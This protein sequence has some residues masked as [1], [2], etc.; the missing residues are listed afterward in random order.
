MQPDINQT[1]AIASF[2]KQEC[3]GYDNRTTNAMLSL[4]FDMPDR[5]KAGRQGI[6]NSRRLTKL[7]NH[8]RELGH[9]IIADSSGI[10][11]AEFQEDVRGMLSDY[12]GRARI[13]NRQADLIEDAAEKLPRRG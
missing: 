5:G 13:F 4:W 8:A 10:Y 2:L 11:Y 1:L 9:P 6:L 7:L 12:R 3:L